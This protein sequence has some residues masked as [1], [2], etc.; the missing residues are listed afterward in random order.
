MVAKRGIQTKEHA[1]F[2]VMVANGEK[3]LCT[4]KISNLYI[5]FRDGYELEDEF[6]VVDMG[7]YDVILDMM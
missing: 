1:G 7:D 4:Q 6:Y 3:L 5:R 2:G